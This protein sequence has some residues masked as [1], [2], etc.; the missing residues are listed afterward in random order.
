LAELIKW[1]DRIKADVMRE[2]RAE[3]IAQGMGDPRRLYVRFGGMD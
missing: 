1:R 2:K 3:M